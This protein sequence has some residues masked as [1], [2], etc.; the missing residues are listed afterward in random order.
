M[1]GYSIVSEAPVNIPHVDN[2]PI[3]VAQLL[4]FFVVIV[5]NAFGAGVVYWQF[6][7]ELQDVTERVESME[8][9]RVSRGEQTDKNFG[10]LRAKLEPL[11]NL[12]EKVSRNEAGIA[13]T[14]ARIDRVVESFAGKFDTLIETV[15]Q[16]K[17][18]VGILTGE[19]RTLTNEKRAT[20]EPPVLSPISPA[21][22]DN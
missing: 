3:S 5:A 22:F 1:A 6:K 12:T 7:A 2:R 19:V 16:L 20:L 9:Y 13:A 10:E 14:N 8:S 18:D 15:N 4:A 11:D 21:A 17:I